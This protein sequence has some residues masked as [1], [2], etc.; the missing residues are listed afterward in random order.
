MIAGFL[1]ASL[2]EWGKVFIEGADNALNGDYKKDQTAIIA[3]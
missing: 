3:H 1:A 2:I